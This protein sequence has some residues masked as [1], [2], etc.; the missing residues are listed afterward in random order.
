MSRSSQKKAVSCL[1]ERRS[2]RCL[3][4]FLL[5]DG[6]YCFSIS[7]FLESKHLVGFLLS[8]E[9]HCSKGAFSNFLDKE[10]TRSA[11][12]ASLTSAGEVSKRYL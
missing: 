10:I 11:T 1:E 4:T 9:L 2:G 6:S 5:G 7:Q 12:F 3:G 8:N